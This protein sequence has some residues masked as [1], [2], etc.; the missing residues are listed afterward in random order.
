MYGG[1]IMGYKPF[2]IQSDTP[3]SSSSSI[4]DTI[5][6]DFDKIAR[7][8]IPVIVD[9][10]EE[11]K[12]ATRKRSSSP[13]N[14]SQPL[15]QDA[16]HMGTIVAENFAPADNTSQRELSLMESNEPFENKY[17]ETNNILRSA[18]IQLDAG[19][20]DLQSDIQ[21]IRRSKTL[22]NKYSYLADMQGS[23]GNLISNKI[24]AAR[25]LNNTITKCN[26]FEM[27]RYKEVRAINAAEQQDDDQK[28]MAM[29]KAFV[30]TPVS[31]SPFPNVS[32]AAVAGTVPAMQVGD[33][34]MMY[35]Q[36]MNTMS[37]AQNMMHLE[38]NPNVK[39]V[40][41]Y[42]QET[43]AR[44]F[45]I[46]DMSTGQTVPN[47]ETHDAMFLED[48]TIDLKNNVARNVNLGETYPLVVV[49]Q[50]LMN[51]Y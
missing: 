10:P 12:K 47:A 31:N 27:K 17:Q 44:Y 15:W 32:Q 18:I 4:A 35:N 40:V 20:A 38:T 41:V 13:K 1:I 19:M 5:T 33:I 34:D 39:Q 50:P 29:Y 28:V 6:L 45:E 25:E 48:V 23:M 9:D 37:P 51:E 30:N 8:N 46:M 26:D 43:G 2:S 22:R 7:M 14:A 21:E 36:Y 3:S 16:P 24:A 49:G 11:P 42:N